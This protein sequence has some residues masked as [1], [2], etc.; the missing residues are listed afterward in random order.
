MKRRRFILIIISLLFA[1]CA[2][3]PKEATVYNSKISEG[4]EIQKKNSINLINALSESWKERFEDAIPDAIT[5]VRVAFSFHYAK[6]AGRKDAL[7]KAKKKAVANLINAQQYQIAVNYINSDEFFASSEFK[8]FSEKYSMTDHEEKVYFIQLAEHISSN[9]KQLSNLTE[10][11]KKK[12]ISNASELVKRNDK[13]TALLAS[14]NQTAQQ[15]DEFLEQFSKS[16]GLP[17]NTIAQ[18][19]SSYA[20]QAGN[21]ITAFQSY[22]INS[23]E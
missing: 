23:K 11:L 20:V 9:R 7:E 19:I 6:K 8:N 10:S 16:T 14:A 5:Q 4:I 18:E 17:L 3:I 2:Q 22:Q 15:D 13:I 1:G 12:V 21:L